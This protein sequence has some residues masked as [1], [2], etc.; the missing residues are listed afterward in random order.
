PLSSPERRRMIASAAP[1][2]D[3]HPVAARSPEL[4]VAVPLFN[5]AD[6]IFALHRRLETT[7]KTLNITYEILYVDDGSQDKTA[8]ILKLLCESDP[9]VASIQLSRNFGHQAAVSAGIDHGRGRAV[10]VMDGDLQDPPEIIP[11]FVAKWREG[12]EVVYAVRRT[13]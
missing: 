4:S 8:A 11:E 3:S 6:N 7:L 1:K 13:R 9:N 10:V 2:H 12:Y 5:E